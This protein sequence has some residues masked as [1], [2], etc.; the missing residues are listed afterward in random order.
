MNNTTDEL[1]VLHKKLE[2]LIDL[3]ELLLDQKYP[4]TNEEKLNVFIQNNRQKLTEYARLFIVV[5][6]ITEVKTD[7]VESVSNGTTYIES[8]LE[9]KT[10]QIWI[11]IRNI[12][13]KINDILNK[14]KLDEFE[15]NNEYIVKKFN[16]LCNN[17]NIK[18]NEQKYKKLD[19]V[20]YDKIKDG[21]TYFSIG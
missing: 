6:K 16:D 3:H 18:S 11:E 1:K 21:W 17:C 20:L 7:N 14:K 13:I 10:D 8:E 2:E 4:K 5:H 12:R 9:K 15:L 19:E